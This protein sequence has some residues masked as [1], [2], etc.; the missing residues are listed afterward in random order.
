MT[1]VRAYSEVA[2]MW[3]VQLWEALPVLPVPLDD[4]DEDVPLDLGAAV[5][6]IY[7]EAA[8]DL[9][10]NYAEPPPPPELNEA[11]AKWVQDVVKTM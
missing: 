3:P 7:E 10:F 8:Y 5:A 6:T 11:E 1:L 9:S 4:P 2:D